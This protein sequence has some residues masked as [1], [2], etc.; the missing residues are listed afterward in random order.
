[1]LVE[2]VQCPTKGCLCLDEFAATQRRVVSD[3]ILALDNPSTL[4]PTEA[5]KTSPTGE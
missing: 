4:N 1:M 3:A 5:P 2:T